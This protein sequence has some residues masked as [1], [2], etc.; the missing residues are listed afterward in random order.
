[1]PKV[2]E[3]PSEQEEKQLQVESEKARKK[4]GENT[5][6]TSRKLVLDMGSV[7]VHR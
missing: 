7:P 5:F 1:L 3:E 6:E 2:Q 4:A